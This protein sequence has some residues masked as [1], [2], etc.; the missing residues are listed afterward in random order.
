MLRCELAGRRPRGRAKRRFMG[1]A[2]IQ[3]TDSDGG[4]VI[5]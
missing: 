5:D 4:Q 1:A 2:R 3:M